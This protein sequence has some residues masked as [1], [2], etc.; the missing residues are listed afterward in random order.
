MQKSKVL[1]NDERSDT[2]KSIGCSSL[3][4]RISNVKHPLLPNPQSRGFFVSKINGSTGA[5]IWV[6]QGITTGIGQW[7]KDITVDANSTIYLTG[8]LN[9][10]IDFQQGDTWSSTVECDNTYLIKVYDGQNQGII[11]RM[12]NSNSAANEIRTKQPNNI[13]PILNTWT[14]LFKVNPELRQKPFF[15]YD[16]T[17]KQIFKGEGKNSG[18]ESLPI[19]ESGMYVMHTENHK[20][21]I[22]FM[23]SR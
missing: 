12:S 15:V 6:Q 3:T 4:L 21:S 1:I 23:I 17:G 20:Q 13:V 19:L 2:L 9:G 16:I 7:T 8:Y 14:D 10:T 5:D 22:R 11:E 18:L